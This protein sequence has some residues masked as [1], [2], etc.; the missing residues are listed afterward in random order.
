MRAIE[1]IPKA[2]SHYIFI[3]GRE[4]SRHDSVAA[5]EFVRAGLIEAAIAAAGPKEAE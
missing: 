2:G 1:I 3:D 5:A 4:V